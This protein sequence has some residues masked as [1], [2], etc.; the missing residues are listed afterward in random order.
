MPATTTTTTA[1]V[2][3]T[4]LAATTATQITRFPSGECVAMSDIL[5]TYAYGAHL[6]VEVAQG[7][8]AYDIVKQLM[9]QNNSKNFLI[10]AD[11][12]RTKDLATTFDGA[13]VTDTQTAI[14]MAHGY[15][16]RYVDTEQVCKNMPESN[17][18]TSDW[19]QFDVIVV[20]QASIL[21]LKKKPHRYRTLFANESKSAD[22]R[23]RNIEKYSLQQQ[24]VQFDGH[25]SQIMAFMFAKSMVH[26]TLDFRDES[27]C[28]HK[29]VCT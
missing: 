19:K 27:Y 24:H 21:F 22:D 1:K 20:L 6:I 26:I 10:F 13:R 5:E 16:Y 23:V 3:P 4:T 9:L 12:S 11:S 14:K 15:F 28:T 8:Q 7:A 17:V 18:D 29:F 2:L 25:R